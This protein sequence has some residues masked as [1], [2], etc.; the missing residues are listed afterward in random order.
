MH[1][2][3]SSNTSSLGRGAWLLTVS[4]SNDGP[5]PKPTTMSRQTILL[6]AK[7]I[8]GG[9]ADHQADEQEQEEIPIAREMCQQ[10]TH[11]TRRGNGA[12]VRVDSRQCPCCEMER[13]R[14]E[15]PSPHPCRVCVC[16]WLLQYNGLKVRLA[17]ELNGTN[18]TDQKHPEATTRIEWMTATLLSTPGVE[19][20]AIPAERPIPA[21]IRRAAGLPKHQRPNNAVELRVQTEKAIEV[22]KLANIARETPTVKGRLGKKQN[23]M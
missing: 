12:R 23:E 4:G 13:H 15:P 1:A 7:T 11:L 19:D 8:C 20:A 6:Q 9:H 22:K 3:R 18:S 10:C 16:R 5:D 21:A 2:T 17:R 14:T